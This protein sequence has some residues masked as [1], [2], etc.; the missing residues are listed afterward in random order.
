MW[1]SV[2]NALPALGER[3]L[4]QHLFTT[5]HRVSIVES[6]TLPACIGCRPSRQGYHQAVAAA[7]AAVAV[8]AAAYGAALAA[9]AAVVAGCDSLCEQLMQAH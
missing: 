9:A 7:A 4:Q 3:T 8:A 5:T 1:G 2:R 6:T